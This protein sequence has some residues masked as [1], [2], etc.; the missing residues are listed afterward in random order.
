VTFA[1]N[2][3]ETAYADLADAICPECQGEGEITFNPA[4][5]DPQGERSERCPRCRGLG[6]VM[7]R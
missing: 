3:D 5:P 1:C 6:V 2:P 4:Y 7:E